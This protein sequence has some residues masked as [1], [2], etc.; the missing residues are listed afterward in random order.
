MVALTAAGAEAR[1]RDDDRHAGTVRAH[2]PHRA[3][4]AGAAGCRHRQGD[5]RRRRPEHRSCRWCG[6]AARSRRRGACRGRRLRGR[7]RRA[8]AVA[9]RGPHRT[10]VRHLEVRRDAGRPGRRRRLSPRSGSPRPLSRA[11]VHELRA[12]VDAIVVGSGTVLADDPQLTVRDP[13]ARWRR[14]SRCASCSTAGTA[15]RRPPACSTRAPRRS[16]STPPCRGSRSRRCSTAGCGTCCSKAAR[17]LAGAFVEARCVDEVVV[18]LAPKLLGDGPARPGR[19][20]DRDHRRS[21]HTGGR[22]DRTARRRHQDRR[23]A[24]LA[25]KGSSRVF[26]G[27]IEEIG[28]VARRRAPGRFGGA[29]PRRVPIAA[30]P[31]PRRVH[32]GE[33]GVPDR[34]RLGRAR[35]RTAIDFDVMAETLKRSVDRRRCSPVR[36]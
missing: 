23:R 1:R 24:D 2:R 20:R 29:A 15:R 36:G 5:L 30:R 7:R 8:A 13:T 11:D 18:Y 9:A 19:G 26:T 31:R 4:H 6:Q 3:V 10:P 12:T 28:E 34:R 16:C 22:R 14:T 25:E 35:R 21:G 32:R 27:I 17:P 33:R